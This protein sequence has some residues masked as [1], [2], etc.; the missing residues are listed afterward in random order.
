MREA[1]VTCDR[2][3][4]RESESSISANYFQTV[5]ADLI[6]NTMPAR[7]VEAGDLCDH[8]RSELE[9][10]IKEFFAGPKREVPS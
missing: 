7:V 10:L 4:A 6:V 9:A 8:C 5:S 1:F 2:C 3:H